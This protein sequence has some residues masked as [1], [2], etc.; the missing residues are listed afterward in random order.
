MPRF[1]IAST[2][3]EDTA[4]YKRLAAVLEFE[5]ILHSGHTEQHIGLSKSLEHVVSHFHNS[6]CRA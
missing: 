5:L 1:E 2:T 4:F 3:P 6:K